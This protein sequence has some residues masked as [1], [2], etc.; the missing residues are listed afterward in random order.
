[1]IFQHNKKQLFAFIL[2]AFLPL[3]M[4]AQEQHLSD[5]ESSAADTLVTDSI[6]PLPWEQRL[7]LQLDSLIANSEL[8]Q[9]TQLGLMVWDLTADSAIYTCN[10]RQRMRPAS[11]MK[12]LTSITA[13]PRAEHSRAT[14]FVLA[15]W[16]RLLIVAT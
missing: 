6:P 11:T 14:S 15:V 12:L 10:H 16:T 3:A 1:M 8:L 5:F 4:Q 9:T 13:I 7:Q 2:A